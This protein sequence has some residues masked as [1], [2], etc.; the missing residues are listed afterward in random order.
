LIRAIYGNKTS[1]GLLRCGGDDLE[2]GGYTFGIAVKFF[3]EGSGSLGCKN[4]RELSRVIDA[5]THTLDQ[6]SVVGGGLLQHGVESLYEGRLADGKKVR[7]VKR[8]LWRA[9]NVSRNDLHPSPFRRKYSVREKI[10]R[11]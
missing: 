3:V 5:Y 7:N 1:Y 10:G 2:E 11:N 9:Q 6:T 4:I 8:V